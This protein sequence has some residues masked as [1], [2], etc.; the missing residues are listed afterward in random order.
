M[1]AL[2][3]MLILAVLPMALSMLRPEGVDGSFLDGVPEDMGKLACSLLL[4]GAIAAR[5]CVHANDRPIGG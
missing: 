3:I 4:S 1:A 5:A 2:R